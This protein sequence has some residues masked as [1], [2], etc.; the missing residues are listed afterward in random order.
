MRKILKA[1]TISLALAMSVSLS[2][3]A[4]AEMPKDEK[5]L[6]A[7][8]LQTISENPSKILDAAQNGSKSKHIEAQKSQWAKDKK[9]VKEFRTAGRPVL[10]DA[11]APVTIIEFANFDCGHCRV[12]RGLVNEILKEYKGK[13]K[14]IFKSV[15]FDDNNHS[16]TAVKYFYAIAAQ[17]MDEAWRFYETLIE[18]QEY[19]RNHGEIYIKGV[20]NGLKIDRQKLA[21]DLYN[22]TKLQVMLQEDKA[23]AE[24][25]NIQG[26]PTF[27]VNNVVIRGAVPIEIIREA[28]AEAGVTKPENGDKDK[29]D[30]KDDKEES[31]KDDKKDNKKDG[32]K[33]KGNK[34]ERS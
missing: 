33:D 30:K 28:M 2:A 10:G 1:T 34:K 9:E 14:I 6:K 26:T 5:E 12:A 25:Y 18:N 7:F 20:A 21:Y 24:K 8:I 15:P 11:S 29:K 17:N 19:L 23:D 13:I 22:D 4:K 16:I 31:K 27:V 3:P 32:N